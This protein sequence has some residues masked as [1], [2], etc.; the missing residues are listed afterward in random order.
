MTVRTLNPKHEIQNENQKS[1]IKNKMPGQN[2]KRFIF[3][4]DLLAVP[5]RRMTSAGE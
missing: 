4:L 2:A 1:N 5:A 3:S